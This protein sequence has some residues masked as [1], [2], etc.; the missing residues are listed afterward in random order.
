MLVF[1]VCVCR[2]W[3]RLSGLAT[4]ARFCARRIRIGGNE[5]GDNEKDLLRAAATDQVVVA[6]RLRARIRLRAMAN[7]RTTALALPKPRTRKRCR[8]AIGGQG[9]DTLGRRGAILINRLGGGVRQAGGHAMPL[10]RA[11]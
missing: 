9:V 11:R 5:T 6:R 1:S 3:A 10:R 7:Q 4:L 8:P 2:R